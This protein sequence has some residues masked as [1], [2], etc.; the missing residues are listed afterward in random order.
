MMPQPAAKIVLSGVVKGFASRGVNV[1]VLAL[2]VLQAENQ[3]RFLFNHVEV[4]DAERASEGFNRIPVQLLNLIEGQEDRLVHYLASLASSP[5][6]KSPD[7]VDR[8]RRLRLIRPT[9]RQ[10]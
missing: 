3:N 4:A 2:L 1:P 7:R 6:Q 8:A 5:A 10:W 9:P